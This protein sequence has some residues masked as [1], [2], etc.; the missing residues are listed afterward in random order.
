MTIMA[1]IRNINNLG[2]YLSQR[3]GVA[4]SMVYQLGHLFLKQWHIL[5]LIG[6]SMI[7]EQLC[8]SLTLKKV[9][10]NHSDS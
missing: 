1:A 8:H 9:N 4:D 6:P 10:H 5:A 7:Q 2:L 3:D